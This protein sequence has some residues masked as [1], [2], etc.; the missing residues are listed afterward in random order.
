MKAFNSNKK[1]KC[2]TYNTKKGISFVCVGGGGALLSHSQCDKINFL[3]KKCYK[4]IL[5]NFVDIS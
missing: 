3:L 2:S 1:V 4:K 5:N